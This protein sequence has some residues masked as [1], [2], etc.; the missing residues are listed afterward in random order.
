MVRSLLCCHRHGHVIGHDHDFSFEIN[1]VTLADHRHRIPR[2]EKTGRRGLVHE[3]I[4]VKGFRHLR[5]AGAP[6]AL[7]MR[8]VGAA[9]QEFESSGKRRR[10]RGEI[11]LLCVS[12]FTA[13]EFLGDR[14]ETRRR[15]G[16]VIERLLQGIGDPRSAYVALECAVYDDKASVPPSGFQ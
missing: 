9:V 14:I 2:T 8:K 5:A 4:L 15:I 16:P 13:V 3:G 1:T 11:E 12:E 10:Q 6:N 7:Y